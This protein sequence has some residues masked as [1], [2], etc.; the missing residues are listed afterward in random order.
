MAF[1]S[2]YLLLNKVKGVLPMI[3]IDFVNDSINLKTEEIFRPFNHFMESCKKDINTMIFDFSMVEEKVTLESAIMGS[4]PETMMMVY[5]SEKKNIFTK[6]GEMVVA[7]YNKFVE[8][9]DKVI[10][11]IKTYSFKKK[12]D[13]QKLDILLKKH[14]EL[15]NEA[16][17]AFN[18]GALDLSDVRS[19]KELDST[20][21]EI[22]KMAKKK[23]IDPDS[24]KGKWEKA[25]KKFEEDAEKWEK[26]GKVAAATTAVITAVVAVKTLS[27]KFAKADNELRE[28]KQKSKEAKAEILAELEKESLVDSSTGKWTLILQI[29][30]EWNNNHSKVI[31]ARQDNILS[32]AD[33]VAAFVD[34]YDKNAKDGGDLRTNLEYINKKKAD[35]ADD[36]R[37]KN[38]DKVTDE[39]LVRAK[40]QRD[41]ARMNMD[42][43]LDR[44]RQRAA[45]QAE[46]RKSV[47]NK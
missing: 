21:D 28:E 7:I 37:R 23:D 35:K 17:A 40:A 5:E 33:K 31:R 14:P 42:N 8:M 18:E 32:L 47:D 11:T 38:L 16:I 4:V 43:D 12:T 2:S 6:I 3:N 44:E 22:L 26:V 45:A 24:I 15:K 46:G 39:T 25:K 36:E 10:D 1:I 20:F 34:K 19:L 13:L 27:S 30:R 41:D 9:I 29:W